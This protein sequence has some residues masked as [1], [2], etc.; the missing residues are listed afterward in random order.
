[1]NRACV[2]ISGWVP[3]PNT[4][5]CLL[6]TFLRDLETMADPLGPSPG[7]QRGALKVLEA[8]L[9]GVLGFRDVEGWMGGGCRALNCRGFRSEG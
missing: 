6:A 7:A 8:G 3:S 9:G 4:T 2:G 1:M 5:R